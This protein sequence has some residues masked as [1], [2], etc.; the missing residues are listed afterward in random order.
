MFLLWNIALYDIKWNKL[1]FA[2]YTGI[3]LGLGW[4]IIIFIIIIII[5][6]CGLESRENGRRDP[7]RYP[8]CPQ[9]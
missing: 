4:I 5:I 1:D 8:R 2:C 9:K 6:I 3:I 7:S